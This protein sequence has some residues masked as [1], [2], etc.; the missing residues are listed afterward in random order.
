MLTYIDKDTQIRVYIGKRV[1]F[2]KL[3]I[4]S[5]IGPGRMLDIAYI[6]IYIE[7]D[8]IHSEKN[9][10]LSSTLCLTYL[11]YVFKFAVHYTKLLRKN[12]QWGGERGGGILYLKKIYDTGFGVYTPQDQRSRRTTNY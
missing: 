7:Q 5:G 4:V 12:G 6:A 3:L 2:F 9:D 8:A 1:F 10:V 11:G